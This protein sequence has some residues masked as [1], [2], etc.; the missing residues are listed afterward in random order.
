MAI[1]SDHNYIV[2]VYYNTVQFSKLTFVSQT[3]SLSSMCIQQYSLSPLNDS[4]EL[5]PPTPCEPSVLRLVSS[6]TLF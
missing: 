3:A 5:L 6:A 4:L 2:E 1:S